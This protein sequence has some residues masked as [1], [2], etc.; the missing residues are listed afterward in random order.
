M[1]HDTRSQRPGT[2][3]ALGVS[4]LVCALALVGTAVG[5]RAWTPSDGAPRVSER[6]ELAV[7]GSSIALVNVDPAVLSTATEMS[8]V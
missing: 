5:V 8:V 1:W 6:A 3:K 2:S 7:L 4:L